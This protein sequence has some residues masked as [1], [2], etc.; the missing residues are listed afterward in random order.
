MD[1]VAINFPSLEMAQQVTEAEWSLTRAT[2]WPKSESVTFPSC[3]ITILGIP[4]S[5]ESVFSSR[6][7]KRSIRRQGT[8]QDFTFVSHKCFLQFI[9]PQVPQFDCAI[10]TRGDH[11]MIH[12]AADCDPTDKFLY[13]RIEVM[14]G[15]N[16]RTQFFQNTLWNWFW[17]I[18]YLAE[19]PSSD[20]ISCPVCGFHTLIELPLYP[21]TI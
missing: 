12:T 10:S 17:K 13:N 18:S 3:I 1:P 9:C 21:A 14:C 4:D 19:W 6:N 11:L 16:I 15:S 8:A 7:N 5:C 2:N 20:T